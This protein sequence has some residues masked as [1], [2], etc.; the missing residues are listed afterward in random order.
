MDNVFL[1]GGQVGQA[2][3]VL[4]VV[5]GTLL[6]NLDLRLPI[7]AAGLLFPVSYTHLRGLVLLS[8]WTDMTASGKSHESRAELDPVLD[9]TYLR[10]MTENYAAGQDYSDPHLSPLFADLEGFPPS[11]I[12]VG[13]NEILRCV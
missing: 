4:G 6:G 7:V 9:E 12:Q 10:D 8:P 13:N 2:G 11:Y 5:L 3:S 1:R